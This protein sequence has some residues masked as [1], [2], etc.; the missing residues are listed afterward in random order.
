MRSITVDSDNGIFEG[1]IMVYVND[2]EHLDN[3]IKKLKTVKGVTGVNRFDSLVE[4]A[5]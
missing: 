5:S 3:L 1:S 4:K 2:T